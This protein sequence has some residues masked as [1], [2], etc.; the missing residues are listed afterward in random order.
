M[1]E[2]EELIEDDGVMVGQDVPVIVT[3]VYVVVSIF[4]TVYNM[5]SHYP[6]RT[7]MKLTV[8]R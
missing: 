6:S 1:L 5:I 7:D 2:V 3:L 4:V 8:P